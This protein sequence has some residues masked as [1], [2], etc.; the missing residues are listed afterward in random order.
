MMGRGGL[1]RG[2]EQN[3]QPDSST[4]FEGF[5]GWNYAVTSGDCIERL[6]GWDKVGNGRQKQLW[7]RQQDLKQGVV[8]PLNDLED[9]LL[10]A[11]ISLP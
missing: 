3:C 11:T 8:D 1:S 7:Q 4:T 9:H 2:L 6:C 10:A 5:L